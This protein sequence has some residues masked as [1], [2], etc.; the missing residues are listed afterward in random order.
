MN[1][2]YFLDSNSGIYLLEK[3]SKKQQ[4]A[5]G[6]MQKAIPIISTQVITENINVCIRKLRYSKTDAFQHAENLLKICEIF[7][8]DE[9]T[10]RKSFDISIN[11]QYSYYD[12][13]IIAVALLS[14][15]DILYPEDMQHQQTIDN[16]LQIINPFII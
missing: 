12:S 5:M 9:V 10:L 2:R 3:G 7:L 14:N 6:L 13:L 4:I 16:Q 8:I 15:C 1:G 11:Y